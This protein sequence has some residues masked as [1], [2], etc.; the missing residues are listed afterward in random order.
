M[1]EAAC[2]LEIIGRRSDHDDASKLLSAFYDEQVERYGFAESAELRSVDFVVP[3]GEFIVAYRHGQP[4]GC[5]GW[6]WHDRAA[7]VAEIKKVFLAPSGRGIGAGRVLLSSIERSAAAAGAV[8][9]ILE[10][11]VRNTEALGLFA[12]QGYVPID[13]YVA[14]RDPAINRAFA[15]RLVDRA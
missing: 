4:V 10:T 7:M 6:R 14:G 8:R 12:S 3:N 11:G 5:G 15:R 1:R 13:R 2:P 9:A